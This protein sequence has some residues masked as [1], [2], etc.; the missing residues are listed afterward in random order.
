MFH[1]PFLSFLSLF[2]A[3][4]DMSVFLPLIFIEVIMLEHALRSDNMS[5]SDNE[6]LSNGFRIDL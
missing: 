4:H 6:G 3:T 1:I 5:N 2:V